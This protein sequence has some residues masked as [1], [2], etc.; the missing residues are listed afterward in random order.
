M[1]KIIAICLSTL[2]APSLACAGEDP[3]Q[4]QTRFGLADGTTGTLVVAR[5]PIKPSASAN[6]FM[7]VEKIAQTQDADYLLLTSG[8]GSAC[9]ASFS[10]AKVTQSGTTPTAF[11]GNCD[12]R[13]SVKVI[14]GKSIVISLPAFESRYSKAA[15]ITVVYDIPTGTL[16]KNGKPLSATCKND[17]C[18]GF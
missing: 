7:F 4:A 1:K 8:G 18:E 16:K 13:Q 11:F 14:Q 2:L 12:D 10:I 6:S 3:H 9:P 5:R 17:A 15:P